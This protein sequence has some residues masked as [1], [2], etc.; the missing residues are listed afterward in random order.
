MSSKTSRVC[1]WPDY[2]K[3]LIHRGSITL[4]IDESVFTQEPPQGERGR[5]FQYANALI[6]AALT[7]KNLFR[8]SYRSLQGFLSSLLELMACEYD[9]PDYTTLCR[10]Q[11]GLK[12]KLKPCHFK[13]PIHL[14]VDSTGLKIYGQGEWCVKKH[15]A[16]YQRTWRKVHLGVDADSLEI[17]SCQLSG[18][19]VQDSAVLPALLNDIKTEVGRITADGAYDTFPCY[20]MALKRGAKALFP[21]RR[22]ARLSSQTPYHKKAASD[23]AIAQRDNTIKHINEVGRQRWKEAVGYHKRSLVET[24]MYRLKALM[25]ERLRAK[26][27]ANQHLELM[28]RACALNKMIALGRPCRASV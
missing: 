8:L 5:P 21:P 15:G 4:W 11:S 22:D 7:L 2:N 24:T 28:L 13:G 10:R 16:T 20:E 9:V 6:E 23:E 1:N 17:V 19:R 25:G 27:Q 3:A 12:F 26:T 18:S 14:L